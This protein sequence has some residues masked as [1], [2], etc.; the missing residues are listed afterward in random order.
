M[1]APTIDQSLPI[2]QAVP[3]SPGRLR[4]L[5]VVLTLIAFSPVLNAGFTNWDDNRTLSQNRR[6][7]PPSV[8]SVAFFWRHPYMDLYAP[9]T[10]T[11][12]GALAA[13][14]GSNPLH[15]FV[16]HAANLL[17]HAASS[18]V[19]FEILRRLTHS[20]PAAGWGAAIFALHPVQ[21]EA[22]AWASGL[23][24]VLCGLLS[25]LAL[26]Q[27]IL[28]FDRNDLFPPVNRRRLR[29]AFAT[30][31]FVLAILAKP[32]AIMLPLIAMAIDLLSLR[33]EPAATVRSL[34][35]W[36][37]LAI[38]FVISTYIWQPAGSE[39]VSPEFYLRTLIVLHALAFYLMKLVV[40]LGLGVDYGWTPH[41]AL[42][43]WANIVWIAP[44][45]VATVIWR[46]R[47]AVPGVLAGGLVFVAGLLP[48]LGFVSFDF[49]KFSTVA[50]H[51]LYIPML[52]TGLIVASLVAQWEKSSKDMHRRADQSV[53]LLSRI[54]LLAIAGLT[55]RQSLYWRDTQ[56]LF[57]H[58]V[59]VNPNSWVAHNQL[60]ANALDSGDVATATTEAGMALQLNADYMPAFVTQGAARARGRDMAGAIRSFRQ[61]LKLAPDN[62]QVMSQ[63]GGALGQIG[64]LAQA[65]EMCQRALKFDPDNVQAHLNLG[66][67]LYNLGDESGAIK[68]L[69]IALSLDPGNQIATAGLAAIKRNHR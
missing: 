12:W 18:V 34:G 11:L 67:V 51:Y 32:T 14:T 65:R 30:V 69:N 52:G 45:V 54:V 5:L 33:R 55:F 39:F 10:Y 63:L 19:V 59:D 1:T 60:A 35:P 24:D 28:V 62:A 66:T 26:W 38:P 20:I 42:Q 57:S 31:V 44:A 7:N 9:L 58:A 13:A 47:R 68:E 15:P 21:V 56:T 2:S 37:L 64:R 25:F 43:K 46:I 16:F 41:L 48:L 50:D 4:F 27:Y 8:Q 29:Y 36:V 40:P 6:L 49:Q 53:K 17:L 22:V 61:A 23:K 3:Y